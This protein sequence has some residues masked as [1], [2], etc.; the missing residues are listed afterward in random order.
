MSGL[1]E[2]ERL[3][4]RSWLFTEGIDLSRVEEEPIARSPLTV[5]VGGGIGMV[6]RYGAVVLF[7]VDDAASRAFIERMRS[8]APAPPPERDRDAAELRR[9]TEGAV[10]GVN[11]LGAIVL[12]SFSLSRLRVV[13]EVLARS[14]VLNYYESHLASVLLDLEPPVARLRQA[15]RLPLRIRTLLKGVGEVLNTEM[16]MISRA[17]VS[18]KPELVWNEPDLDRLYLTLAEEYELTDRDQALSRKLDLAM[19]IISILLEALSG[20]RAIFVEWVIVILILIE[21][22]MVL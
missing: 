1:E 6:Y 21:V 10:E 9:V 17:E 4:A 8:A 13:A 20:R 14:A 16:R 15:G 7:G 12:T 2:K 3:D 11:S 5:Q 19:R 18:E 22:I